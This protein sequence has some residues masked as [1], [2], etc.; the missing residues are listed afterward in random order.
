M[1]ENEQKLKM[2]LNEIQEEE[3]EKTEYTK[4]YRKTVEIKDDDPDLKEIQEEIN[5]KKS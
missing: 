1:N 5:N 2:E 4:S 3:E